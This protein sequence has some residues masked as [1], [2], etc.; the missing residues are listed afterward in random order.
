MS[1]RLVWYFWKCHGKW[2]YFSLSLPNDI[3]SSRSFHYTAT[4]YYGTILLYL[5]RE[6]EVNILTDDVGFSARLSGTEDVVHALSRSDYMAE[7]VTSL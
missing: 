2:E 6:D 7:R 3:H 4:S 5:K 1:V